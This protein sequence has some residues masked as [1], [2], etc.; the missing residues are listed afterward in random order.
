MRSSL[1]RLAAGLAVC[2][3]AVPAFAD[4]AADALLKAQ[5]AQLAAPTCRM[6][7]NTKNV[8]TGR[9]SVVVVESV[10]SYKMHLRKE[11]DGKVTTEMFTDGVKR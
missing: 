8:D 6:T 5:E 11:R 2:T 1:L 7:V 10:G 9:L 3:L 4:D